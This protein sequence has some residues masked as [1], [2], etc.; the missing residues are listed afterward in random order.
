MLLER[1]M[2]L[3]G[4]LGLL[5]VGMVTWGTAQWLRGRA[6]RRLQRRL[7]KEDDPIEP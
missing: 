7:A 1:H 3:V 4:L 2:V 6:R 5:G